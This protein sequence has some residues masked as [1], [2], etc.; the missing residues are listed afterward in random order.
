MTDL[1]IQKMKPSVLLAQWKASTK[2][3]VSSKQLDHHHISSPGDPSK[4]PHPVI[5]DA[6]SEPL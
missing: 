5:A 4:L 3:A 1:S 2:S 6:A